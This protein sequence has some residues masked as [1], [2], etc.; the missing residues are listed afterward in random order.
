VRCAV[1]ETHT[2]SHQAEVTL[3]PVSLG[4]CTPIPEE[5]AQAIDKPCH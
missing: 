4:S 2:V 5:W 3:T 1:I